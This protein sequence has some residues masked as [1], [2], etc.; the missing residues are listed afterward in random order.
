MD[1]PIFYSFA[2]RLV[3]REIAISGK[4][5]WVQNSFVRWEDSEHTN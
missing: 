3:E 4:M 2:I 1:D 5:S